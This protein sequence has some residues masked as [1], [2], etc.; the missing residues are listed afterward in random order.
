MKNR[1]RKQTHSVSKVQKRLILFGIKLCCCALIFSVIMLCN[2][3]NDYTSHFLKKALTEST[4]LI[5]VRDYAAETVIKYYN[6][7]KELN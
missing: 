3:F 4:D 1:N 6:S 5:K 7:Y 2:M